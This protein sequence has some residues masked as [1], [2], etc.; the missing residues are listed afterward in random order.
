MTE[1]DYLRKR[2]RV[3]RAAASSTV[4]VGVR[5]RHLE[6]AEAYEFRVRET[7]AEAR[8][9]ATLPILVA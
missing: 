8:R 9:S 2:A 5:M 4:H 7:E 3:E 1:L 6:F